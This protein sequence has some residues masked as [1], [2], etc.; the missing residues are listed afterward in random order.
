MY[1]NCGCC[2]FK[3]NCCQQP[4]DGQIIAPKHVVAMYKTIRENSKRVDMSLHFIIM[5]GICKAKVADCAG[6]E[7]QLRDWC[8]CSDIKMTSLRMVRWEKQ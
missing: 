8:C 6:A 4:E 3:N 5:H 1:A 2:M 7:E